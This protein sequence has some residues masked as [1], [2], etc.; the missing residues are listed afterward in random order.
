[1]NRSAGH[2]GGRAISGE[3]ATVS[4]YDA[5]RVVRAPETSRDRNSW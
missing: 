1:M 2:R 3:L 4:V 5:D